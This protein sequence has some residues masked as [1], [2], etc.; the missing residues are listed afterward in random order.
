MKLTISVLILCLSF[1]GCVKKTTSEAV[2]P[3][4]DSV[5]YPSEIL[6]FTADKRNPLFKGTG[7]DT[8]DE[9]IRERGYILF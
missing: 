3:Q 6:D 1:S 9:K 4:A 2:V 7:T 8:W 5:S